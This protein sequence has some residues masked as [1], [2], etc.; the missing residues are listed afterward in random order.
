[1]ALTNYL[2]FGCFIAPLLY[3]SHG[4]SQLRAWGDLVASREGCCSKEAVLVEFAHK[5]DVVHVASRLFVV[6]ILLYFFLNGYE[7][8][9]VL[10]N[11]KCC[12]TAIDWT[13]YQ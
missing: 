7:S 8:L 12:L 10:T 3:Y 4:G 9:D 6:F 11:P 1:M 13:L 5:A 2:V